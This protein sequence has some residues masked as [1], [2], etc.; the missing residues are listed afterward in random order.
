M[1]KGLG[2]LRFFGI[3]GTKST[4]TQKIDRNRIGLVI[5]S[6]G[7]LESYPPALRII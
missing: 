2:G 3:A 6:I 4:K 5:C 7:I 1:K